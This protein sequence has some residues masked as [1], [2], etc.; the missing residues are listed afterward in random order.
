MSAVVTKEGLVHYE[1]IGRGQPLILIHGW[2]GSWRYWVPTMEG[3]S[4]KYKTYAFDLWGFGD[5]DKPPAHYNIN[6][7]VEQLVNFL[8]KLGVKKAPIPIVGHALGG[9]VA[10]QFAAQFPE[11]VKQVMGVSVPLAGAAIN[12]PLA[13]FSGNGD[14]LARLVSRR[15][16]F[17]EVTMEVRKADTNAV[18][19]SINS[20]MEQDI[21]HALSPISVPVLLLYGE[22]DPLIQHPQPEWLQEYGANVRPFLMDRTQHFPMLE[23]RNKFNRLLMDFLDAG[24]DLDSLELKEEWQRRL[25]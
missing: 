13:G 17:D 10:L 4:I 23:E 19:L 9:L 22:N 8:D 15:A 12:R 21:R 18:A 25:R 11:R 7:Y 16:N 24:D 2:L 3:L 20:A 6:A 5:S 1:A 14:A